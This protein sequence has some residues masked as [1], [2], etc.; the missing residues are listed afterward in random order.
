MLSIVK[1]NFDKFIRYEISEL[2]DMLYCLK[3]KI[4]AVKSIIH[5][6]SKGSF[7][8]LHENSHASIEH[9]VTATKKRTEQ[10]MYLQ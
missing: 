3:K 6:K 9:S 4:A 5:N 8:L 2:Y 7:L 10:T 1:Y